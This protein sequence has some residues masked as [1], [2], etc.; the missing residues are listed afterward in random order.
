MSETLVSGASTEPEVRMLLA[1][2][3]R[4]RSTIHLSV[5]IRRDAYLVDGY[6]VA[7]QGEDADIPKV[8]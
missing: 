1:A 5:Q 6:L 4:L 3:I 2:L 7:S 8:E